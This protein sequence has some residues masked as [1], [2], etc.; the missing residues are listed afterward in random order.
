M[1]KS[2]LLLVAVSLLIAADKRKETDAEKKEQKELQGVWLLVSS[3]TNGKPM[4][5]KE[6]KTTKLIFFS[7]NKYNYKQAGGTRLG[8]IRLDPEAKP[9]TMEIVAQQLISAE[10][11]EKGNYY[12]CI[13]EIDGDQLKICLALPGS[14]KPTEFASTGGKCVQVWKREKA[15]QGTGSKGQGT[16]KKN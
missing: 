10:K 8:T 6:V 9:K 3:E 2:A 15:K 14:P 16:E 1:R 13:Y 12:S 5:A 11:Y 7:G 4:P